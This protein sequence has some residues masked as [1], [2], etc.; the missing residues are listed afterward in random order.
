[1]G[2]GAIYAFRDAPKIYGMNENPAIPE[3]VIF[4]NNVLKP[5]ALIGLGGVVAGALIHYA[6]IGPHKDDGE[7]K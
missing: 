7:V 5:L 3:S 1:M 4:W 2:L 6:V